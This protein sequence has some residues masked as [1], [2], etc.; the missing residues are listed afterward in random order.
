[1]GKNIGY[2]ERFVIGANILTMMQARLSMRVSMTRV[3]ILLRGRDQ[4]SLWMTCR[5][6]SGKRDNVTRLCRASRGIEMVDGCVL[7]I[8][9]FSLH[10]LQLLHHSSV[11]L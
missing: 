9:A 5:R 1:M 7:G 4:M 10:S 3:G 6:C 11:R 2:V 8:V